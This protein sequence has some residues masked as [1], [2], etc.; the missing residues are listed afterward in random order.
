LCKGNVRREGYPFPP[1]TGG[2]HAESL[3]CTIWKPSWMEHFSPARSSTSP[4]F[5]LS[6]PAH[7][8]SRDKVSWSIG[9]FLPGEKTEWPCSA[10]LSHPCPLLLPHLSTRS[11]IDP[12]SGWDVWPLNGYPLLC[13]HPFSRTWPVFRPHHLSFCRH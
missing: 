5:S 7:L 1:L 10:D 11:V 4:P 8:N 12:E 9:T 3:S 2:S 6:T 13:S